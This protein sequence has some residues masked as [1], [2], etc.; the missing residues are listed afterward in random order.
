MER[1][2]EKGEK[3]RASSPRR[4]TGD[5]HGDGGAPGGARLL[6]WFMARS[7]RESWATSGTN[8]ATGEENCAS[9]GFW[10]DKQ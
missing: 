9:G 8:C 5:L 1:G 6:R 7:W 2:K 3:K 10:G 4:D